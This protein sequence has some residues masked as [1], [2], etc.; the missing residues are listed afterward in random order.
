MKR[1]FFLLT[2]VLLSSACTPQ[3]ISSE[4]LTPSGDRI[5]VELAVTTEE[6]QL[7]LMNRKSLHPDAGML[8]V[9]EQERPL[10]FWMKN[11][12]IPLDILYIDAK[13][14][15]VDIQ[16]MD[17]CPPE[18]QACPTYP[19]AGNAQYALEIN[20]GRALELEIKAGDPLQFNLI[21]DAQTQ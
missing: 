1:L 9:F 5:R 14:V 3:G 13:Q 10:S 7:G 16:T 17:P 21:Q 20:A 12:L 11:T 4:I 8:F 15:V 19:S 18:T 2:S 6:Q